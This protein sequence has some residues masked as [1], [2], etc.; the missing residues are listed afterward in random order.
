M[1]IHYAKLTSATGRGAVVRVMLSRIR[2]CTALV[3]ALHDLCSIQPC[4]CTV[5]CLPDFFLLLF[6]N[7]KKSCIIVSLAKIM[8]TCVMC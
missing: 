4:T 2:Q 7:E 8:I 3:F 5:V 1:P 6:F